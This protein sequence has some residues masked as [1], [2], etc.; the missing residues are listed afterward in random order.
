MKKQGISEQ[1]IVNS[2][3]QTGVSPKEINDA[4]KQSQI[5]NAVS[6]FDSEM[7]PAT[8]INEEAPA[9]LPNEEEPNQEEYQPQQQRYAPQ[10]QQTYTPMVQEEYQPQEYQPQEQYAQQESFAGYSQG[11]VNADTIIEIADQIFSDRIR[12]FQKQE[13]NNSEAVVLLQTKLENVSERLKKIETTIDKLQIAI[14]E[15]VGSYGQN[16]EGIKKEMSMM[17]DSFSKMISPSKEIRK[18]TPQESQ[19]QEEY[20]PNES[21]NIKESLKKI[22]RKK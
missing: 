10:Q 14:L 13:D 11:G 5:K 21:E 2:L 7:E 17:Q 22:S 18:P 9:P 4:L 16:L 19:P 1:E 12:K 20:F 6:D 3:S 8:N 15:K